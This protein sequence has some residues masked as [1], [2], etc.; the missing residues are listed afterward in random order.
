MNNESSDDDDNTQTGKQ[1]SKTK[2]FQ[3]CLSIFK[4]Q[5][6]CLQHLFLLFVFLI[7]PHFPV[8]MNEI[9]TGEFLSAHFAWEELNIDVFENDFF[10][11]D[12][13]E[14]GHEGVQVTLFVLFVAVVRFEIVI[15]KQALVDDGAIRLFTVT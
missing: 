4:N 7:M 2:S 9:I 15:T 10:L 14:I 8:F 3:K 6:L 1:K 5:K 12:F 13:V 11:D